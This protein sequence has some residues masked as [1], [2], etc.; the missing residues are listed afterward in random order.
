MAGR[1]G[2]VGRALR[3]RGRG[4]RG[5]DPRALVAP[6]HVRESPAFRYVLHR[7]P[8]DR[9]VRRSRADAAHAAAGRSCGRGLLHGAGVGFRDA[10]CTRCTG[11]G[12]LRRPGSR[13]RS[14]RG[15]ASADRRS[16]PSQPS[17]QPG[18]GRGRVRLHHHDGSRR[19][20]HGVQPG[21]RAHVRLPAGC[22]H[23][24]AD[25]RGDHPTPATRAAPSCHGALP[26]HG[27]GANTGPAS[28][29]DRIAG[30]W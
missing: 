26:R 21:R 9:L 17:G 3:E 19:P 8:A 18:G 20:D 11:P 16:A 25:G 13:D 1:V 30:R 24:Q 28:R 6:P 29:A 14:R 27:R 15:G 4:G 23:W 7:A 10:R 2:P 22:R 5:G 12:A